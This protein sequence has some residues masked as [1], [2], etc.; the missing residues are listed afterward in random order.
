MS[1]RGWTMKFVP[2]AVVYH[3]HPDTLWRY[4]HKKYK[5]AFWRVQAVR[6]N[7]NKTLKDSHTP[8]LMKVQLLFAPVLLPAIFCDVVVHPKVPASLLVCAAFLVSTLPFAWR[9]ILKDP[10]VGLLSPVLLAA[11][12][13]AQLLGVT[14]GLIYACR[15]PA[16]AATEPQ[17]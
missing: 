3:T 16:K 13:C 1:A 10:I 15:K 4:V 2:T 14:S 12:A 9:A 11:R 5:F 6:K 17:A 7:P 8:Q